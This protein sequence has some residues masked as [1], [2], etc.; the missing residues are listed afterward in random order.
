M[1][2][3]ATR[4]SAVFLFL[5]VFVS[6]DAQLR[7][8]SRSASDMR[9]AL[10]KVITDYSK[11]FS[12]LKGDLLN[13]SDPQRI[14]YASLLTF[15][16]A[17]TNTIIRYSGSSPVY[18]WQAQL[19]TTDDFAV[20]E[21]KYNSLYKDLKGITLTLNRD[22]T[23]GLEGKY[24]APNESLGFAS[25]AFHLTPNAS[26]LSKIKVELSLQYEMPEWKIQ[27]AVY[28]KEKEDNE[29]GKVRED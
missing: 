20:A 11:G 12:N 25:T 3:S 13:D 6:A 15:K 22:Y 24:D 5:F 21:K 1:K 14:E 9:Q 17:E 16:T 28:Q 29:R 19:L 27:L 18:S 23:F 8:P 26:G 2:M 10:E 7:L 4:V